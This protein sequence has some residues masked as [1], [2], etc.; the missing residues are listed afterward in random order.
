M[1]DIAT[2]PMH[3]FVH[4]RNEEKIKEA[5]KELSELLGNETETDQEEPISYSTEKPAKELSDEGDTKQKETSKKAQAQEDTDDLTSEEKSFKKRY[6][7]IRRHMASKEKEWTTRLETLEG[8][9]SKA[10]KN[11]LVLPKSQDEI[12][13]WAEKYP[14]VAGIVEAI[15]D[16][17]A[18]ERS[19]QL[20]IRLQEVEEMRASAKKEKA[21]VELMNLHPDFEKIRNDD[22]FHDWA[23][24][25]PKVYQ[26]ALYDNPDDVKSVARV[27][28]LYKSDMGIKTKKPNA[29]KAAASSVKARGRTVVDSEDSSRTLSESMVKAMSLKEYEDR[30]DE[31]LNAMR[32]GKF[33]YD[34]KK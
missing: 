30:Q 20:D 14:D 33:I 1:S 8:Q 16:K 32:S 12:D 5:E 18:T 15:A 23:D 9:L 4:K 19:S 6:G 17:K 26:D 3:S 29:D 7:D 34:L 31:I 21:E 25:Q 28:D 27:I 10:A 2:Q 13:A 24:Q 22:A 11:E